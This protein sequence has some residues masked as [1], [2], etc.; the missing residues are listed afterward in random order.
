MDTK[1][2]NLWTNELR[3]ALLKE[4]KPGKAG[5]KACAVCG[6]P[7]TRNHAKLNEQNG[8][9]G[10]A[11]LKQYPGQWRMLVKALENKLDFGTVQKFNAQ[12]EFLLGKL[13]AAREEHEKYE[14][15]TNNAIS[16]KTLVISRIEETF[17]LLGITPAEPEKNKKG[18]PRPWSVLQLTELLHIGIAKYLGVDPTV[19]LTPH[20]AEEE[21]KV[22]VKTAQEGTPAGEQT[23]TEIAEQIAAENSINVEKLP[24]VEA[25]TLE[26]IPVQEDST[27]G[28]LVAKEEPTEAEKA[29]DKA[30]TNGNTVLM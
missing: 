20:E 30:P 16:N 29:L 27:I 4:A 26:S 9:H 14:P 7:D 3:R 1:T 19:E 24:L 8:P 11:V 21:E 23:K 10:E 18:E 25:G 5:P 13:L 6:K 22:E 17:K 2:K 15:T 28:D 12:A